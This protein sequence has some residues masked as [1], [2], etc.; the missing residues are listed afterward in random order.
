ML[1]YIRGGREISRLLPLRSFSSGLLSGSKSFLS[2]KNTEQK[3]PAI[4]SEDDKNFHQSIA[5]ITSDDMDALLGSKRV[6]STVVESAV[7]MIADYFMVYDAM[8]KA[9]LNQE[10]KLEYGSTGQDDEPTPPSAQTTVDPLI[11]INQPLLDTLD[12]STLQQVHHRFFQSHLISKLHDPNNDDNH[13]RSN[14]TKNDEYGYS[15]PYYSTQ[16]SNQAYARLLN[17]MKTL[18]PEFLSGLSKQLMNT[19]GVPDLDVF[20]LLIRQLTLYRYSKPAQMALH[21]LLQSG[22]QLNATTLSIALK[23][24]ASSGDVEHFRRLSRIFDLREPENITSTNPLFQ[25]M[26]KLEPGDWNFHRKQIDN[27]LRERFFP[28]EAP[29]PTEKQMSY[30]YTSLIHGFYKFN[31]YNYI[32]MTMRKMI[33]QGLQLNVYILTIN[34]K[35]AKKTSDRTRARWTWDRLI[36]LDPK[37]VDTES[38][39][40]AKRIAKSLSDEVL[41]RVIS[42]YSIP[43]NSPATVSSMKIT[44]LVKLTSTGHANLA[45]KIKNVERDFAIP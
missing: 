3:H 32:D 7:R 27:L 12:K 42:E 26:S 17:Y 30:L 41:L 14:L 44:P 40:T 13:N 18:R 24:A 6:R 34:F 19:K 20:H 37:E 31:W 11:T 16:S 8:D 38:F 39:Q 2:T 43:T 29:L 28:S 4:L 15:S 25:S 45:N 1:Y 35:V 23:L 36:E 5:H 22:I 21:C 10:F 9:L 33:R